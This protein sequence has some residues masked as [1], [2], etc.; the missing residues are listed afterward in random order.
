MTIIN[1]YILST[2]FRITSLSLTTFVG[3]YLLVDFFEKVDDFLE[4]DAAPVLYFQYF[5][6]KTPLIIS[7][8][9]PLTILM[10]VFL[11]LGGFTKSNELTAM[12]AGGIGLFRLITPLLLAALLLTGIHFAINEYVMPA[13]ITKANHILRT[14]VKGKPAALTKQDNLWFKDRYA[15]YHIGLVLPDT[16]QMLDVSVYKTDANHQITQRIEAAQISYKDG[17]WLAI[18]ATVLMFDATT[19][20]LISQKE[21]NNYQ[22]SLHN[23]PSD[24]GSVTEK[25]EELNFAQLRQLSQ[26]LKQEGLDAT[27]YIVNMHSRLAAP[28]ACL[29]MAFIAIPFALQKNRN[30]NLALGISISVIIGVAFFIIQSTLIAIGFAGILPPFVAAWA[31]NIIFLLFGAFLILSTN[32]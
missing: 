21:V 12:R 26:R 28:F 14:E 32:D 13:S 17:K 20:H 2:F 9:L 1:K 4:H 10:G 16:K 5:A 31:T 25:H 24:F 7:Q 22:L 18:K 8:V 11:T 27:R 29:I 19:S 6:C 3:I 30:V 23:K 15:I